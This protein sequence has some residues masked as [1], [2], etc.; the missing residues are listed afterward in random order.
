MSYVN[1]YPTSVWRKMCYDRHGRQRPLEKGHLADFENPNG[2]IGKCEHSMADLMFRLH[3]IDRK[4]RIV[5]DRLASADASSPSHFLVRISKFGPTEGSCEFQMILPLQWDIHQRW[6]EGKARAPGLW[7]I[8][9]YKSMLL[10]RMHPGLTANQALD[11]EAK[12]IHEFN[13]KSEADSAKPLR[14]ADDE[15]EKELGPYTKNADNTKKQRLRREARKLNEKKL[16]VA[17]NQT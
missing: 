11:E 1:K 7:V 6:P 10:E 17:V 12:R 8:D 3:A 13:E 2:W 4:L 16:Q 15:I 14:D 5:Y 9:A